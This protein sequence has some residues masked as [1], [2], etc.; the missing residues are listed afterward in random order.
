[1]YRV[2]IAD[3]DA[4]MRI[5]LRTML[6]WEQHGYHIV[7]EAED[8]RQALMLYRTTQP[9]IVITDM[10]MPEMD[11]VTLIKNLSQ[12]ESV[13]VILALSGYDDYKLVREAMKC[14]AIDYLLKLELTPSLLLSV[15][16]QAEQRFTRQPDTNEYEKKSMLRTRV[17]RDFVSRFYLSAVE[18]EQRMSQADIIFPSSNKAC[19]LIKTGDVFRFEE[20]PEEEYH[21]LEFSVINIA[22]EIARESLCVFCVE[23]KTGEFYLIGSAMKDTGIEEFEKL[24][25]ETAERME[26]MLRIYLDLSCVIGIGTEY[27]GIDALQTA[28]YRAAEVVQYAFH[29]P[30]KRVLLFHDGLLPVQPDKAEEWYVFE[31]KQKIQ[32]GLSAMDDEVIKRSFAAIQHKL[33]LIRSREQILYMVMMLSSAVY[34][35]CVQCAIPVDR[36]LPE[37]F[38]GDSAL[39]KLQTRER[40]L[41]WIEQLQRNIEV[42]FAE[43]NRKG[44]QFIIQK[45]EKLIEE[46]YMEEL[47]VQQVAAQLHLSP[48]YLSTLMKRYTRMSFVEYMTSVRI[49][50]AK[51]YLRKSGFRVYE[52]AELVGYPDQFYF[53]RIFKRVTGRSP[54]E[55]RKQHGGSP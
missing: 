5:G 31:E 33:S 36:L 26:E 3:D 1:M 21:T 50:H 18:M 28:R 19:F 43:E 41:K 7:A 6:N 24:C 55:Y 15:L 9:D 2:L 14:G 32:N 42:Y 39:L 49:K 35:Y 30:E 29:F 46:H 47:S 52:I 17:L 48:G 45:A 22:Q 8:G 27:G 34:E 11:G 51:S 13:P 10:K 25:M 16:M 12:E 4:T 53:S 40:F 54:A 23:G 38:K 37:G 20:L 44:Y